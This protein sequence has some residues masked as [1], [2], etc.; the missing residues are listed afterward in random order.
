VQLGP[1]HTPW[2][3]GWLRR[4]TCCARRAFVYPALRVW[5]EKADVNER[6]QRLLRRLEGLLGSWR[7]TIPVRFHRTFAGRPF[8]TCDYCRRQVRR[9]GTSYIVNKYC[10]EG[11]LKQETVQCHICR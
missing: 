6:E 7:E 2:M 3:C 11:Q 9:P 5:R 1:S 4:F 10:E 8:E